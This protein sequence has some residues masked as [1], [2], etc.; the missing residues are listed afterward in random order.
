MKK[1][2][3]PTKKVKL[4]SIP[5]INRRLFKLWSEAVKDRANNKC[6]FCGVAKG[7]DN[8][9][10]LVNKLDSHH[11]LSRKIKNCPLKFDV[12]NGV[13]ADPF[14]HK[15]GIP[16]FHRDPVTTITWL[17]KNRPE[18]HKFVLENSLVTVDLDNRSV[19][20]EIEKRLKAKEPLDIDKLKEIEKQF[21]REMKNTIKPGTNIIDVLS[22]KT[23]EVKSPET[24]PPK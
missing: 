1:N 20:A 12:R 6:E 5:K 2:Q 8:G 19:L 15:F 10:G 11:L 3:K 24:L 21:P 23:E 18:N 16:S 13:L 14:H 17:I 22:G 7:E 9:H 4:D